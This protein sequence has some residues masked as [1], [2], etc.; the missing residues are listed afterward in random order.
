MIITKWCRFFFFLFSFELIL[1]CSGKPIF[2]LNIRNFAW[3]TSCSPCK[4]L[5]LIFKYR[6]YQNLSLLRYRAVGWRQRMKLCLVFVSE[7][8]S[9]KDT[10]YP[11]VR[12]TLSTNLIYDTNGFTPIKLTSD[13]FK[14]KQ[15][16]FCKRI[17]SSIYMCV[18]V[19]VCVYKYSHQKSR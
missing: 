14:K 15:Q 7:I 18:C 8:I 6:F 19:C 13:N 3:H 16:F 1:P 11:F 17:W 4:Y 10:L 5:S 2:T 9:E 12:D